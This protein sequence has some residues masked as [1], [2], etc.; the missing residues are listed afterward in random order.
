[1][2]NQ[3]TKEQ[4][5]IKDITPIFP[6]IIFILLLVATYAGIIISRIWPISKYSIEKAGQF[7]DSFGL[8]T[9]LFSGLAFAGV[10][11]TVWS[12]REE[13]RITRRELRIQGFENAFFQ[14]LR[15]HNEILNEINLASAGHQESG[16]SCFLL[17]K[18]RLIG[19]YEKLKLTGDVQELEKVNL[20]Y[21]KFW[22]SSYPALAHYFRFL[23]NIYEFIDKT[24]SIDK[25]DKKFYSDLVRAQ[26]SNQE[27]FI[28]FY[29]CLTPQGNKFVKY[30][31]EYELF[32]NLKK[33]ELIKEEH[34]SLID[35]INIEN[36]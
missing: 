1:M 2:L 4:R 36:R 10:I 7:G 34:S 29:N 23:F 18:N 35:Q 25:S 28:L 20:A 5:R 3:E 21:E 6:A 16:R 14:M 13:L 26:L 11:W 24:E 27:L 8:L 9:S 33:E 31:K 19:W 30:A 22:K 15:L 17:F 12:Q 32:D